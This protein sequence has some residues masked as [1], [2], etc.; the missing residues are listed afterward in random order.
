MNTGDTTRRDR[1]GT[2]GHDTTRYILRVAPPSI[3]KGWKRRMEVIHTLPLRSYYTL[4]LAIVLRVTDM[5]DP[6]LSRCSSDFWI[7][8]DFVWVWLDSGPF[9]IGFVTWVDLTWPYLSL[10]VFL[11]FSSCFP[12]VFLMFSLC[13][14]YDFLTFSAC[15]PYLFFMFS[16]CFLRFPHVFSYLFPSVSLFFRCFPCHDME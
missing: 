1:H 4:P 12:H 2:T 15:F 10:V 3:E 16:F 14:P 7:W 6:D 11:W 8:L 13:F 9:Q 5:Q